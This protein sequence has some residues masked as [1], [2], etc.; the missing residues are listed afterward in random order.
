M[1]ALEVDARSVILSIQNNLHDRYRTRFSILKELVQNADDAHAKS[2]VVDL[3]NGI[4]AA[5]NPLLRGPGLLVVNDGGYKKR[6]E[7]GIRPR[8]PA[9]RQKTARPQADL[10]SVRSL[11]SISAMLLLSRHRVMGMTLSL[12]WSIHTSA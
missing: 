11:C 3:R 7:E 6:D 5:G 1:P 4:D 8:Q 2:L 10:A 12:L 9:A